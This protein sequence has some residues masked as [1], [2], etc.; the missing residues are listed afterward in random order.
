MV[1]LCC[2]DRSTNVYPIKRQIK[3]NTETNSAGRVDGITSKIIKTAIKKI[4]V[5]QS[6]TGNPGIEN[7]ATPFG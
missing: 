6:V 3:N 5:N 7:P 4:M 1:Y 2:R